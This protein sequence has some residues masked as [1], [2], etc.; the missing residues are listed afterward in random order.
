MTNTLLTLVQEYMTSSDKTV[1][2]DEI[3]ENIY[4][5]LTQQESI[6]NHIP[7]EIQEKII[8]LSKMKA[9]DQPGLSSR[10]IFKYVDIVERALEN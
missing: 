5:L 6:L 7:E 1:E 3:T 8:D 2:V 9:K 10:A 4:I